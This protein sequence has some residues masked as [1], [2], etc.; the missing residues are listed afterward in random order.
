MGTAYTWHGMPAR[1]SIWRLLITSPSALLKCLE[2][3]VHGQLGDAHDPGDFFGVHSGAAFC[4]LLA[5]FFYTVND[6]KNIKTKCDKT[7]I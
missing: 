3:I 4:L 1:N 6:V 2:H 7:N 5:S